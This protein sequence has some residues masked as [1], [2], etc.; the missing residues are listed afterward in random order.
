MLIKVLGLLAAPVELL[1]ALAAGTCP[2]AQAA[3]AALALRRVSE[4]VVH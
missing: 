1:A 3:R 4:Q 2:V